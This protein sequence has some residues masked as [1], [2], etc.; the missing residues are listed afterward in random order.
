VYPIQPAVFKSRH[1]FDE[2]PTNIVFMGWK[3]LRVEKEVPC[4]NQD[5]HVSDI[6]EINM[7]G[8]WKKFSGYCEWISFAGLSTLG[9]EKTT[10]LVWDTNLQAW[11]PI[12][13][14]SKI[15]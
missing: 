2:S 13:S 8:G 4:A 6:V 3:V 7:L 14:K 10:L 15:H 11:G 5:V 9:L 1:F 12:V